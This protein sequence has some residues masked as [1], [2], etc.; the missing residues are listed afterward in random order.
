VV[1]LVAVTKAQ[2]IRW[3]GLE[4]G[5]I[6]L[7]NTEFSDK[8]TASYFRPSTGQTVR[9]L[10]CGSEGVSI[11]PSG[12]RGSLTWSLSAI[13]QFTEVYIKI[14]FGF[15][16]S[17]EDEEAFIT[18]NGADV[19]RKK[20]TTDQGGHT[21]HVCG[22]TTR[23]DELET[24]ERALKLTAPSTSI[25][26][27]IGSNLDQPVDNE[28]FV[29]SEF[30]VY[31]LGS[32]GAPVIQNGIPPALPAQARWETVYNSKF[33]SDADGWRTQAGQAATLFTCGSE[34]ATIRQGGNGNYVQWQSST[35]QPFSKVRVTIRFGFIDSWDGEAAWVLV[36]N[37]EVWRETSLANQTQHPTNTCGDSSR[38]PRSNDRFT[39]ITREVDVPAGT[40]TVSVRVASALD[41]DITNESF[42]L[43]SVRV[44]VMR[45]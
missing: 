38:P 17:W 36:N 20:S 3:T 18:V 35:L 15:I 33:T 14:R 21:V 9:R 19:W 13:P 2:N 1:L 44:E 42:V 22:R 41:Q 45:P 5:W 4:G 23:T 30:I 28:F 27:V 37:R 40:T 6:E 31:V 10:T 7:L 34:G 11:S 16:D 39:T 32:T 26:V 25:T 12:P 43:P 29:V 24:I 8:N